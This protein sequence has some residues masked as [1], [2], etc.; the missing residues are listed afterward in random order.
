M[1][2]FSRRMMVASL[3]AASALGVSAP[4]LRA[5]DKP[6]PF[7]RASFVLEATQKFLDDTGLPLP[8][9]K[10]ARGAIEMA[11][12]MGPGSF[13]G[14]KPI[15]V[16][17]YAVGA[18]EGE[19]IDQAMQKSVVIALPVKKGF[20][21][22]DKL[23]DFAKDGDPDA[24]A[25]GGDTVVSKQATARRLTDYLLFSMSGLAE[26]GADNPFK[27]DYK[28]PGT[29][30][31]LTLDLANV[32][33]GYPKQ[34]EEFWKEVSRNSQSGPP[35]QNAVA[36]D[37]IKFMRDKLDKV[38]SITATVSHDD[39]ALK[40]GV[41]VTPCNIKLAGAALPRPTFPAGTIFQVHIAYPDANTMTW[42]A[43]AIGKIDF[44]GL[45]GDDKMTPD[46]VEQ[47]K[48][49][50]Q[51]TAKLVL[52]PDSQSVGVTVDAGMPL[53][54]VVN[55]YSKPVDFDKEMRSI[56]GEINEMAKKKKESQ[57]V[58]ISDYTVG[59][60]K[61]TRLMLLEKEKA[62]AYVDYT[63][64]GNTVAMTISTDKVKQAAD[65]AAAPTKGKLTD[66]ISASLDLGAAFAAAKETMPVPD[67]MVKGL[68]AALAGQNITLVVKSSEDG[69][70]MLMEASAPVAMLK[71][72]G[73]VLAPMMRGPGG[74]PDGGAVPVAPM[75]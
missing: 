8:L 39:K 5:D 22:V 25:K 71:E 54:M 74:P 35:A 57:A 4:A 49:I 16:I 2:R 40:M 14:D 69:K 68:E 20:A 3:L 73:K 51:R 28:N 17:F 67:D 32:R 61:V 63:Q 53:V 59:T 34:V 27:D 75:E 13:A 43:D 58:E 42:A 70:S 31:S 52:A 45:G 56:A 65:L 72:L 33:K 46:E 24:A 48:G 64:S 38:D 62:I 6:V 44:K 60:Q 50:L 66:F 7:I 29:L 18:N 55:Q 9:E 30:G 15:G 23:L 26:Q 11:P 12:F 19:R 41:L 21:T 1:R 36:Q 10:Q 37:T 47:F